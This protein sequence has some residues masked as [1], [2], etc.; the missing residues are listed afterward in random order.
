MY[1]TV[2]VVKRAI[3]DG[4]DTLLAGTQGTETGCTDVSGS[5]V[6]KEFGHELFGGLW[7]SVIEQ[8][9]DDTETQTS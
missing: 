8:F 7:S 5:L 3:R 9:K 1:Y 2:L 4:R 6:C